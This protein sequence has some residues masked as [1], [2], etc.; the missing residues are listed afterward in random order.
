MNGSGNNTQRIFVVQV[1]A[2][3]KLCICLCALVWSAMAIGQ[4]VK[5]RVIDQEGSPLP[6]AT[7]YVSETASGGITNA[8][9]YY[10]L[11]LAPGNYRISFQY[12]G[13]KTEKVEV[14]VGPEMQQ[15]DIV[16]LKQAYLLSEA[17]IKSGKE[18]PAYPIMRKAIAKSKYHRQQV[19]RYS[20]EVYLKG[21][22][23]LVEAPKLVQKM[24]EKEGMD[25]SAT[26]V[27]E[28]VSRITYTR[29]GQY[30]EEV[31]R[32]RTSGD[33]QQSSPMSYINGSFYEPKVAGLE[34]PLSPRA[35][36]YYKFQYLSSFTDQGKTINRIQV[37]P[38][39]RNEDVVSGILNLV[40]GLWSI[41][42]FEFEITTQGILIE[43]RQVFAPVLEDVW[44]P[45]SHRYDGGGKILGVKF[46]FG[47]L[48][49]VSNYEV[50]L[51][52]DLSVPIV[53]IDEKTEKAVLEAREERTDLSGKELSNSVESRLASGEELTRKELRKLM[54]DYERAERKKSDEPEVIS[55]RI[56]KIDSLAY[57]SDSAYWANRR[58]VPLTTRE[59]KG[60]TLQDSLLL[61]EKKKEEGDTLGGDGQFSLGKLIFGGSYSLGKGHYF[62][63]SSPLTSLNYNTVDGYNFEYRVAWYK[64]FANKSRLEVS[65]MA[66]VPI[67][68]KQL[69]GTLRTKYNYRNGPRKG[70]L[71][72]EG[73]WYYSQFNADNPI[74][75]FQNSVSSLFFQN[76][77]MKIYDRNFGHLTW[78]HDV[79]SNLRVVPEMWYERRMEV[80][81]NSSAVW[82]PIPGRGFTPNEPVSRELEQTGFGRSE[83]FKMRLAVT[84]QPGLAFSK[85]NGR[86]FARG[87][88]PEITATVTRAVPDVFNS[89]ID[90]TLATLSFK[91]WFDLRSSGRLG[92]RTEGGLF[93]NT[94]RMEF[95]DFA[96]FMGNQ[97][98]FTR[99]GQLNG[100]SLLEYYD[101]STTDRYL[102]TYVNFTGRKL[103]LTRIHLLRMSGLKENLV[104]NHLITPLANNYMEVGYS[105]TNVFRVA[106]IDFVA[107]FIDG[108]YREFRIQVGILS[109]IFQVN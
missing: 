103:L 80:F 52:P 57:K 46:E 24:L 74:P 66:R 25:T 9:G 62:K 5:G 48:A 15:R 61:E 31:I 101:W 71:T 75:P 22:G 54:R 44:L 97:T 16:L 77:F 45:V 90:Y 19:D 83:A 39:S 21:G 56:F 47:Y 78:S 105:L 60:Y 49:A 86:Y 50:E 109:E 28:S 87:N 12:L 88:A 4:G 73:G 106:R 11:K 51:N 70:E 92:I 82:I 8:S 63:I 64:R 69:M 98:V 81:N 100:F 43:A 2:M 91:Y 72:L 58:P 27:S 26:F 42:S 79:R 29:P 37:I 14:A 7:I 65:P 68:R 107:G 67:S 84:Y 93:T 108:R 23:R 1:G 17:E 36:G 95:P 99:F 34:S 94:N 104:F 3:K 6:F 32:I 96:H 41:H 53:V 10:E 55:E 33:D 102:S 20:C 38:R 85:Y 18:D 76:N 59:V 13:Y 89:T 30:E 40:E 35:F